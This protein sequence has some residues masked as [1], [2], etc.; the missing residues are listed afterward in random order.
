MPSFINHS[1]NQA[2]LNASKL[3]FTYTNE[4]RQVHTQEDADASEESVCTDHMI[5]ATWSDKKGWSAPELKSYGPLSLLPTS[6]CLHYAA[7]RFEGMKVYRGYDG[8]LRIFR[9]DRN[10]LRFRN[11]AS[12]IF[13][14]SF[15]PIEVEKLT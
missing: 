2:P 6:S 13:L 1:A 8:K 15:E 11:S 7:E 4:P 10:T 5:L 3:I 12:R 14:P 9:P